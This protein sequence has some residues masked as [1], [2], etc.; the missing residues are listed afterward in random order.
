MKLRWPLVASP[1]GWSPL[2]WF[3]VLSRCCL[4]TVSSCKPVH[5]GFLGPSRPSGPSCVQTCPE[6][7]ACSLPF[8]ACFIISM[9]F[10][11]VI[12]GHPSGV[13]SPPAKSWPAMN[14][15][16]NKFEP[17]P[18]ATHAGK[19]LLIFHWSVH[20]GSTPTSTLGYTCIV[21]WTAAESTNYSRDNMH[22]DLH[23]PNNNN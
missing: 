22:Y 21:S 5:I 11:G 18:L 1:W 23:H 3:A 8:S 14:A 19:Q 12:Q 13:R 16:P 4:Q 2:P 15:S 17:L 20:W 6:L 7:F 9:W 10:L